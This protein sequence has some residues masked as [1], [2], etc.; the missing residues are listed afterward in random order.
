MDRLAVDQVRQLPLGERVAG[1]LRERIV[2]GELEPGTHLVEGAL[3]DSFDVSRGPIRDALRIL[4]S[5]GLVESRRRGV[6]VT[7]LDEDDIEE[8]F[9]LR[10]SMERLALTRAMERADGPRAADL[11]DA[12]VA[13]MAEAADKKD[14]AAFAEADLRFHTLFYELAQHRRLSA[15]WEQHRPVFTVLLDVTNTQDRDLRPSVESHAG[16]VRAFRSGDVEQ[17][18][19]LLSEHILSA[20]NRLRNAAG[21]S[22]R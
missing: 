4:E 17:A 7:G 12:Q 19:S 22:V 13:V 9:T 5:E 3:A 11:L 21:R 20:G 6:F 8:L 16:L 15:A 2:K 14:P 18:V 10:E 1:Q